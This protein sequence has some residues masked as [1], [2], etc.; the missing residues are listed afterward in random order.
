MTL[1]PIILF[2]YNRP[3]HTRRTLDALKLNNLAS[4]SLL[5]IYADGP[6]KDASQLELSNIKKTRKVIYD[7]Q[8]CLEVR[9]IESSEN[10]GLAASILDGVT[11]VI[12]KHGKVVV[13]ED[14]IVVH[15]S[16]LKYMNTAL[17]YFENKKKVFHINGY[18]NK[19]AF[20]FLLKDYY[21]LHFMS[22]WGWG[23]WKDRW[24][25]INRDHSFYYNKLQY[26]EALLSSFNYENTLN[27]HNQLKD[28]ISGKIRT[29]AILW[30]STVFFNKALCVTPKFSLVENIGLDGSGEHCYNAGYKQKMVERSFDQFDR[31]FRKM[32]FEENSF[33]RLHLKLFYKY[34]EMV[35][36]TFIKKKVINK[37]K[38]LLKR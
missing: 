15:R 14:D 28:N 22:C 31:Y 13:L 37:A 4:K 5:Y 23:T 18:S 36:L 8:W 21:F 29:W 10:K 1:A 2:V 34:G 25:L 19:S 9:I 3:E 11:E 32:K 38:S 33:S 6:K 12:E 24:S 26:D 17:N 7:Q 20:Q 27:F 35:S 16:F 30:Y